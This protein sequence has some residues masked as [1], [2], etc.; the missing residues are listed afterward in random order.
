M[1]AVFADLLIRGQCA[2]CNFQMNYMHLNRKVNAQCRTQDRRNWKTVKLNDK[3][4]K[5]KVY[6]QNTIWL[7]HVRKEKTFWKISYR[8]KY[9]AVRIISYVVTYERNIKL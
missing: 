9:C 1:T 4:D 5:I 8:C 3:P 6:T 2:T 7:I